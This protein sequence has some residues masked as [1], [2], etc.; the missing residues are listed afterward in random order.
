ME[1]LARAQSKWIDLYRALRKDPEIGGRFTP[2]FVSVAPPGYNPSTVPTL[3]YVG[4]AERA[5]NE[6]NVSPYRDG[7]DENPTLEY[8]RKGTRDFLDEI[9][10][11]TYKSAFWR[12]A[13]QLGQAAAGQEKVDDLQNV[14]WT[15]ICKL[16]DLHRG[17]P[18]GKLLAVQTELAI[19][20]LQEEIRAYD[21]HFV[22]FL[23][24][25]YADII[26]QIVGDMDDTSWQREDVFSNWLWWRR[27][28]NGLPAILWTRHPER[29]R[30]EY[31]DACVE[32]LKRLVRRTS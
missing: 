18:S 12:F 16:T 21:P 29:A 27:P 1:T 17:N 5:S 28:I 31:L 26:R 14:V 19:E 2:P 30:R 13:R 32:I 24:D 25:E 9:R 20:T 8:C 15:N 7:F 4:K 3:L 11:G 22:I 10:A 23:S 6:P